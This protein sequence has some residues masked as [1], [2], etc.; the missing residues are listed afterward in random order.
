M[1]M[2]MFVL[3]DPQK[4]DDVL[5]AW[6]RIGV[7]GTTILE[8]TSRYRRRKPRPI[9]ARY[10]FGAARAVEQAEKGQYTLMTIVPSLETAQQC[11]ITAENVVGDLN[12]PNTG[13][14]AAWELA[15]V[16]GVP[17]TLRDNGDDLD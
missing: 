8:S 16:K 10:M 7:S 17:D 6:H 1:Y 11:Q 12:D 4:L 9:G 14:I 2:V 13:I 15:H 5:D 3:D